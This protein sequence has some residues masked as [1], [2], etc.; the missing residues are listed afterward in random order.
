MRIYFSCWIK[1]LILLLLF[2]LFAY[3]VV[4]KTDHFEVHLATSRPVPREDFEVISPATY[5]YILNQPNVCK[6]RAPFLVFVVP[7]APADSVSRDTIRKT[8]GG[9]SLIH[10]VEA[11][12]LFYVGL[13]YEGNTSDIQNGLKRESL[14]HGDIIQMDFLDNYY[15]LTIKTIMIMNWLAKHCQ[16]ASYAMKVDAD[17]FVNVFYLVKL[18]GD[19]PRHDYITGSVIGDGKPRRDMNSKWHLSEDLYPENSF[20]PYVSGAGYVFSLDLAKRISW[21][22]TFVRMIPLE[23]VYVGLCLRVLRVR[24]VYSQSLLGLRNLFEVRRFKYDRCAYAKRVI[25]NGF[26]PQELMHIWHDFMQG[27]ETC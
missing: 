18:L 14:E 2:T 24:P 7:V 16:S 8:W 11:L 22:S 1:L 6:K 12:T 13:H 23:D 15:N 9:Q 3:I 20:P 27:F 26:K 17:I 4:S 19:S 5:K 21:A 10:N 25:V